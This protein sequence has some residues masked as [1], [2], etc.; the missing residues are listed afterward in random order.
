MDK[1]EERRLRVIQMIDDRAEFGPLDDG[2]IYYFPNNGGGLQSHEL[3]WIADELDK[4]N[5]PL[6]EDISKY[7]AGFNNNGM[8]KDIAAQIE[9]GGTN[10]FDL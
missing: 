2:F 1:N 5:K 3:R 9:G 6:E 10:P 8:S 7:F 4:R